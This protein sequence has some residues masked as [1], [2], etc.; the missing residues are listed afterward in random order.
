MSHCVYV[1]VCVCVCVCMSV[2]VYIHLYPFVEGHLC[3]FRV[4]ADVKNAAGSIGVPE[5]I[6]MRPSLF[7]VVIHGELTGSARI[8]C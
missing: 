7:T 6:Q 3:C 8:G 1:R 2:D 4:L 5:K